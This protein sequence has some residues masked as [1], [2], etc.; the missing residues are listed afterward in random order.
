MNN[1]LR[2]QEIAEQALANLKAHTGIEGKWLKEDSQF[3]KGI[4]GEVLLHLNGN[5]LRF[6]VEVKREF[7]EYQMNSLVE[8][9][10]RYSPLLLISDRLYPAQKA[11]LREHRISYL[12]AAG[13]SYISHGDILLWIEGQKGVYNGIGVVRTNRAFTKA[14]L[15]VVFALLQ[16][17]DAIN[18]SYRDLASL[19]GVALGTI[20]EAMTALKEAGYLLRVNK[21][22]LVLDNKKQL[23]E[24]WLVGYGNV[25]KPSLLVGDYQMRDTINWKRASLPQGALWGGE[26]AADLVTGHLSPE[27]WT[28]YIGVGKSEVAKA[29]HLIPKQGGNLRLFKKFWTDAAS[30]TQHITTPDLITY[31][32]LLLTGDQRCIETATLIYQQKLS[33]TFDI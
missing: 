12:D 19:A 32:D 6:K 9:A 24:H 13:N 30:D 27:Q 5:Q 20:N 18:Y 2:E 8:Q 26:P 17:P 23:L 25:L 14:G 3:G 11:G 7:R 10:A 28:I 4:D 22:R 29:L 33:N 15:K 16:N 21:N 31:A 1:M